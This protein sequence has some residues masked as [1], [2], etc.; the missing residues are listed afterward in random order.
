MR[1]L[2]AGS[3]AWVVAEVEELVAEMARAQ[4][5]HVGEDEGVQIP[6]PRRLPEQIHGSHRSFL[7]PVDCGRS[8][9]TAVGQCAA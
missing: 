2:R 6:V 8:Q 1:H 5:N 4:F 9:S 3:A 7:V